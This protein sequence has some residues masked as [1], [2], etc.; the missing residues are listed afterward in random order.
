MRV[1]TSWRTLTRITDLIC[2]NRVKFRFCTVAARP[3]GPLLKPHWDSATQASSAKSKVYA[4]THHRLSLIASLG[5][6]TAILVVSE[7][8]S[9]SLNRPPVI[10]RHRQ[11][12]KLPI[13]I[14]RLKALGLTPK[15]PN[16]DSQW[17]CS[18]MEH[19][20]DVPWS[21]PQ[22]GY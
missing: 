17:Q 7:F 8:S 13:P 2:S 10:F 14:R 12:V 21:L 20:V 1:S 6:T 18:Q 16:P 19:Q 3:S 11:L 15:H 22:D 4:R 9:V 5:E